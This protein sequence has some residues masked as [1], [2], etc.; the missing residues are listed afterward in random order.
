MTERLPMRLRVPAP[1]WAI[2]KRVKIAGHA[3]TIITFQETEESAR[4]GVLL[5]RGP[6]LHDVDA[7]TFDPPSP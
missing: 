3:G 2:D 1:R 5:D 6:Y 4:C 7:D